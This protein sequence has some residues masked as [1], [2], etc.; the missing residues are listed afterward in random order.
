MSQSAK[1]LIEKVVRE[2][3]AEQ[4]IPLVSFSLEHPAQWKHGDYATNVALIAAK[5]LKYNSKEL[6]TKIVHTILQ[7]KHEFLDRVETAGPGFINF[8]ISKK[9]FLSTIIDTQKEGEVYGS[10]THGKKRTA[11]IEFS[12]PNI[13]K[14]F[15]IGHLRSTIIGDAL[16][17]ILTFSGYTVVRDNHLGDWG[18]QFGKQIVAM[19][20]WGNEDDLANSENPVR[21]LVDLYVKFHVEA[22]QDPSLEDEARAWFLKL[23][24]GDVEAKRLWKLCI[25]YSMEHFNKIYDVL[26]V[27]FDMMLGE[28]FFMDK[29]DVVLKELQE[30]GIAKESEGALLVFFPGDKYPPL[31]IRKKDGATLYAT[32]DLATDRYRIERWGK[33][34]LII[35]EVGAE[36]SMYFKQ[37]YE[38]E[39]MAGYLKK[40]QR[41]HVGHGLMRFK[42]G[43]MSTR[44][45]NTIW[46]IDVLTDAVQRASLYNPVVAKEV[47]IGALKY[48]DLKRESTRDVMFQW[49][50]I[51]NLKGNS[52]PYLQYTY[53]RAMSVLRKAKEQNI[54]AETPANLD[55]VEITTTERLI[56]QF[57]EIV[58]RATTE[59]APHYICTYVFELAQAFN[60]YYA[61]HSILQGGEMAGYRLLLTGAVAQVLKNGL[62]LLGVQTP[63]KM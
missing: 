20:R 25:D 6:A 14:P 40:S 35:N 19:K 2:A 62:S 61:E 7:K 55:A 45:G 48:N 53:A 32:R 18:T 4:E 60:T 3:L 1:S 59:Y 8:F 47:G 33:D 49:E 43:K 29:M 54:L 63:E 30:K 11:I 58:E 28:S 37:I 36:Q 39:E 16:A 42:E 12:S 27:K 57:P 44:K 41:K 38:T 52:G 15:T 23:E 17:R 56:Y 31:M 13:A 26:G 24:Q 46:L 34:V 10:S 50:D 9:Y 22:E 21:Y 5:E 51:L